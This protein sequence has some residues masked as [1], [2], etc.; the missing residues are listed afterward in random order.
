MEEIVSAIIL[1]IVQ[2]ISEWLPISSTGHLIIFEKL[3]NYKTGLT[4]DVALHF[5][6]LMAVFV[7]FGKDIVD[8]VEAVLKFNFKGENGRT[9]LF[10]IVGSIP[11]GFFG[12]FFKDYFES[13]FGNLVLLAF[14]FAITGLSLLIASLDLNK[15]KENLTYL[16]SFLIGISQAI[17]IF[18]GIS[19]S[20]ATISSG[21][22]LGLSPKAAARFSFLLSIPAI[23]GASLVTIG[24]QRLP[25]EL[26]WATLVAFIVGLSTIHLMFKI[27]LSSKKN[28]RWFALYA[29]LL[30]LGIF[31]Y[32]SL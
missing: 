28:L 30:S 15:K 23:F 9:A 1:A 11:A 27:V 19:R 14:G 10:L 25:I 31:I 3:L 12:F 7:Y 22:L 18:P 24:N 20:G 5:G 8:I 26:L 6:T 4:F 21:L 2:G 17:A 16:D 13:A 29:F 32:L